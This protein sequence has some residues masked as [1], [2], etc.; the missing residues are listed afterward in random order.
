M[1]RV[2][3]LTIAGFDPSGGAG[4]NADIKV[5]D[6][7]GVFGLS[8]CTAITVQTEDSFE[9]VDWVGKELIISQIDALVSR[10]EI[11]F[12]KI[13]LI[14]DQVILLDVLNVIRSKTEK[15][16]V[17]WDPILK[18]SAGFEFGSFEKQL[19]AILEKV[20]LVTP[21]RAEYDE[22]QVAN[23]GLCDCLVTGGRESDVLMLSNEEIE[24]TTQSSDL[25][26]HGTGCVYTAA[27]LANYA[28]G[29]IL[30]DACSKAK[31][32][33]YNYIESDKSLLGLHN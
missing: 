16:Y 33:V 21:N 20:D 8:V 32:Y 22:L 4:L 27:I 17:L 12:I 2:Y 5:F 15:A 1:S 31:Q 29:S 3:C 14:E 23:Y 25:D 18:A 13:G 11:G 6:K 26:K 19:P 28:K 10:Y 7:L 30:K 24:I 9:Q